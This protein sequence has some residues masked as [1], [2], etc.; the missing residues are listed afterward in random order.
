MGEYGGRSS[1][2]VG[3][4]SG[5]RGACT[6]R[7]VSVACTLR[8]AVNGR[9]RQGGSPHGPVRMKIART[10]LGVQR[11][12]VE[13][14]DTSIGSAGSSCASR[15]TW[16]NARSGWRVRPGDDPRRAVGAP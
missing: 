10:A 16:T 8:G 4:L 12:V 2:A 14:P 3:L 7:T 9:R 11:V 1:T 15:Q 6:Q 5:A 13:T